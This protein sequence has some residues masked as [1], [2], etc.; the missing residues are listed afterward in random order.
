MVPAL[1]ADPNLADK[2]IPRLLAPARPQ[3]V[4]AA[5]SLTERQGGS[6]VRSNRTT[7]HPI[8]GGQFLLNGL[9]WFVTCPWADIL[10]VLAQAPGGLT[11]FLVESSSP[12]PEDVIS[13]A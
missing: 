11:C 5:A 7:A 10:L 2:W 12:V 4:F 6:D 3:L 1:R 8:G 9:K 13:S